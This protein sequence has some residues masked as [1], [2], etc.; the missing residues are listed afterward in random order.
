[1]TKQEV[2]ARIEEI[3][4]VPAIRASSVADALFAAEAVYNAGISITEVTMTIP[5]AIDVIS[6]LTKDNASL[7]VG[8]EASWIWKWRSSAWMPERI[9]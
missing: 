4:I 3:G 7:I 6:E 9:S 5:G 8:G 1:M 2:K